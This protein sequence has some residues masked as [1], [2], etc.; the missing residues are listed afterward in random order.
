VNLT[1]VIRLSQVQDCHKIVIRSSVNLG[2]GF[3]DSLSSSSIH[4][5]LPLFILLM[6]IIHICLIRETEAVAVVCRH[7]LR[8]YNIHKQ[9]DHPHI[10]RLYDVFEIDNNS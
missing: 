9:L 7:A 5:F 1:N 4:E 2:P 8:E 6:H 10:V 3:V